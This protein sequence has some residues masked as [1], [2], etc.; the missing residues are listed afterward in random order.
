MLYVDIFKLILIQSCD[1]IILL[2]EILDYFQK[3]INNQYWYELIV[4]VGF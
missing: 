4:A 2:I 1:I 3:V